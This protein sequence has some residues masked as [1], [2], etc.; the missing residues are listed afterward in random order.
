[1]T[2]GTGTATCPQC[3]RPV[4]VGKKTGGLWP[5]ARGVNSPGRRDIANPRNC[6]GH[7]LETRPAAVHGP[8]S[9]SSNIAA[10]RPMRPLEASR[11]RPKP[12]E[13]LN[14]PWSPLVSAAPP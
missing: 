1:M 14:V 13:R 8:M 2:T 12:I 5:H 10:A 7:R 4:R 11:P 6:P 3:Q 9:G